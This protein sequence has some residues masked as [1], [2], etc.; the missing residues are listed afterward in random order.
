M[1]ERVRGHVA[2]VY[3]RIVALPDRRPT[4]RE[5]V[6]G[7]RENHPEDPTDQLDIQACLDVIVYPPC[8]G[9]G[10]LV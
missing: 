5:F 6:Q 4:V 9:K 7:D 8:H 10:I 2:G 3:G 1:N